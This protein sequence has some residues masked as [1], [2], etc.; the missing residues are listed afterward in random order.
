MCIRCRNRLGNA[1]IGRAAPPPAGRND[2]V[3]EVISPM[4][5]PSKRIAVAVLLLISFTVIAGRLYVGWPSGN[6]AAFDKIERGWSYSQVVE[7]FGVEPGDYLT[8]TNPAINNLEGLRSELEHLQVASLTWYFTDGEASILFD[9][10]EKVVS[11]LWFGRPPPSI[12][13]RL[14]KLVGL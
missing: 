10:N 8:G 2:A 5:L 13:A 9:K 3:V 12:W 14:C 11:K 4:V 7:A 6:V 1:A